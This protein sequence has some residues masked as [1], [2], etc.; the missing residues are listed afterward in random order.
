MKTELEKKEILRKSNEEINKLT[1]E[2]LQ[3]ALI[4]LMASKKFSDI[5]ITE[6]VK[7]AGVSRTAFY[8]NYNSKEEVILELC[9]KIISSLTNY[10]N[11]DKYKNN[12]Y[13]FFYDLFGIIRKE[14]KNFDL[15]LQANLLNSSTLKFDKFIDKI[16]NPNS[17]ENHYKLLVINVSIYALVNNWFKAGMRESDEFMAKLCTNIIDSIYHLN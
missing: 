11:S 15:L 17:I 13:N 16:F 6:L 8:R 14:Y 4:T 3:T 9:D 12:Y 10:I 2:C 1:K 5:T 7:K